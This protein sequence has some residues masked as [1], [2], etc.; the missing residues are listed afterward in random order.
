MKNIDWLLKEDSYIPVRDKN[1]YIDKSIFSI[2]GT[3]SRIRQEEKSDRKG[4]YRL[5]PPAKFFFT[6][7]LILFLA[8]SRSFY[9]VIL[10]D[11]YLLL[12]LSFLMLKDIKKILTITL[13]VLIFTSILLLPS[14][15]M[16]N[17]RNSILILL[18]ISGTVSSLNIMSYTTEFRHI[19]RS[20][21]LFFIPDIFILIL[22][23]SLKY[24]IILGN[25]S[26]NMLY[27]LKLRS[28]G[29]DRKKHTSL[30]SLIGVLFIKSRDM[31][32]ETLYAMEC[33]GFTGEY[34]SRLSW[35]LRFPDILYS[36]V[37]ILLILLFFS[38]KG[39]F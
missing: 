27:A 25:F 31:A 18:K 36:I 2:L 24:I 21:K 9:Y 3:L 19:T 26:L 22:D 7:L 20:L 28:V 15:L 30:S 4:V 38:V 12:L 11:S 32:T 34:R 16:G 10:I 13:I 35:R 1:L 37:N 8:L 23:M 33:R 5:S 14:I 17:Q 6:F 29:R 39:S